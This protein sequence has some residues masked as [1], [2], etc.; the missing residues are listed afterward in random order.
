MTREQ[1]AAVTL[2]ETSLPEG[3]IEELHSKRLMGRHLP[4]SVRLAIVKALEGRTP[5][6]L[7]DRVARRWVRHGYAKE[8]RDGRGLSSPLGVVHALVRAGECPDL[9][10]EDG[11]M[12]DTGADCRACEG[13]KDSHRRGERKTSSMPRQ[14]QAAPSWTCTGCFADSF[15]APPE[16]L[17]CATCA[18]K[19]RAAFRELAA[20]LQVDALEI[21]APDACQA[22]GAPW[23]D[24]EPRDPDEP[25]DEPYDDE[26]AACT[27]TFDD[28]TEEANR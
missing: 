5:E 27:G 12:L 14:R 17:Q 2:V 16:T 21:D 8:L 24:E 22:D 13:R 4:V 3:L 19:T 23:S 28:L 18:A 1:A 26:Q 9:G 15:T 7:V 25:G 6:Q 10:C 20:R 11:A